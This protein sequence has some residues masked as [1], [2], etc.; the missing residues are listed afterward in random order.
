MERLGPARTSSV[1]SAKDFSANVLRIVI[2]CGGFFVAQ[3]G[4][5]PQHSSGQMVPSI[6]TFAQ[7]PRCSCCAEVAGTTRRSWSTVRATSPLLAAAR[8]LRRPSWTQ[9]TVCALH[10]AVYLPR[11][12]RAM[13]S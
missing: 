11:V 7:D 1:A 5:G 2:F 9:S 3:T 8:S 4:C 13:I 6:G 10:V 12:V